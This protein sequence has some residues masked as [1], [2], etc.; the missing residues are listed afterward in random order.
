M[1]KSKIIC[2]I[3]FFCPVNI[4]Q[5]TVAVTVLDWSFRGKT[6]NSEKSAIQGPT[7]KDS[8][9]FSWEIGGPISGG[10]IPHFLPV[11][12]L[13]LLRDTCRNHGD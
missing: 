13:C 9:A 6:K 2:S 7:F 3:Y 8:H 4:Y 5:G 12:G 10:P 1:Y 11:M